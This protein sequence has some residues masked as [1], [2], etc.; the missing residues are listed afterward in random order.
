MNN[1][2]PVPYLR[3]SDIVHNGIHTCMQANLSLRRSELNTFN[4]RHYDMFAV[5]VLRKVI[6]D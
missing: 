5:K 2:A 4:F 6:I 1:I 3:L